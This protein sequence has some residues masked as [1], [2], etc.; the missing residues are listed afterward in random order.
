MQR[1]WLFILGKSSYEQ[2]GS[3]LSVLK[4]IQKSGKYPLNAKTLN[5][6]A[7][8][9]G[10]LAVLYLAGG[11]HKM[12]YGNCMIDSKCYLLNKTSGYFLDVKR[13]KIW[14]KPLKAEL[15]V[16]KLSFIKNKARWGAYI[17]GGIKEISQSDYKIIIQSASDITKIKKSERMKFTMKEKKALNKG[18]MVFDKNGNLKMSRV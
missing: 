18:L 17:Q 11:C 12:F 10:D 16:N 9:P 15:V 2:Q 8:K 7:L 6:K 4:Q 1:F 5:K 3:L 14:K 13:V